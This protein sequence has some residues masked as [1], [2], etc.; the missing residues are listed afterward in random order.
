MPIYQQKGGLFTSRNF[1]LKNVN[2]TFLTC[3]IRFNQVLYCAL[4]L[5]VK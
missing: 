1:S 5:S 2:Q 3:L 4:I